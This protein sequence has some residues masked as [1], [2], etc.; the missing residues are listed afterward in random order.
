MRN[1]KVFARQAIQKVAGDGFA[2]GKAN[3]VHKAVKSGPMLGQV[4]EQ[5][6][7]LLV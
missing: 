4:L 7:N 6:V 5:L 2:R 3:A 1:T